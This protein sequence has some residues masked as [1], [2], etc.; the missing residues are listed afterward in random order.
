[1]VLFLVELG[2]AIKVASTMDAGAQ[3]QL[4][5]HQQIRDGL[6]NLLGQLVCLKVVPVV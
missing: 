2:A 5:A 1:L 6:Q 3:Q 4:L